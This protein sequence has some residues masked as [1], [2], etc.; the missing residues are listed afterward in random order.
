MAEIRLLLVYRD[1]ALMQYSTCFGNGRATAPSQRLAHHERRSG[2]WRSRC[3]RQSQDQ[4]SE[5]RQVHDRKR[6]GSRISMS[7]RYA[8]PTRASLLTGRYNFRTGVVDTYLGRALMHPDEVT[9]AEMLSEAG[10]RTGI[11][12]KWHLGDN[13]PM[14]PIDQGFQESLVI[15]GAESASRQTRRAAPAISIR[16]FSIKASK[17]VTRDIAATSSPAP[18]LSLSKAI[19]IGRFSLTW[20]STV[21]TS[22]SR[23][24]RPTWRPIRA[25]T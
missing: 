19:A 1:C 21:R 8:A 5:P 2:I 20:P 25:S 13:A 22:R 16:F 18:R 10:Y 9:L 11:F 24:P 3:S 14:R 7:R 4:D 6:A 17:S 12:G 15:K 23:S